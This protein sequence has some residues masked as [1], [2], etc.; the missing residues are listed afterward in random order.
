MKNILV[1][2][3]LQ[4]T[5]SYILERNVPLTGT[6]SAGS[7]GSS[8]SVLHIIKKLVFIAIKQNSMNTRV[9]YFY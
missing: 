1:A 9:L 5:E 7:L 2:L 3:L 8:A 6:Q 4:K